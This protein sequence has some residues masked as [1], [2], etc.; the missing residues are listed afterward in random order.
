MGDVVVL[1]PTSGGECDRQLRSAVLL[2]LADEHPQL[3][4]E[5]ALIREMGD[6][7]PVHKTEAAVRALET[8]G[9]LQR[10]G[11]TLR[12]SAPAIEALQLAD[13]VV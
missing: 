12:V 6:G 4:G 10:V 3:L 13:V 1:S 8:S 9:I 11:G 5:N 7:T 2:V